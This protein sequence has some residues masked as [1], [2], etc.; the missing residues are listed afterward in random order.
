MN[1]NLSALLI[2]DYRPLSSVGP[3]IDSMINVGGI[4][5]TP[6]KQLPTDIQQFLDEAEHGAIYFSLGSQ[7]E[8]K[9]MPAEKL[10]I[11]LQVFSQ[12]KQRVLWKFE[13]DT[14]TNLPS[15]VMVK[16][17]LPQN[18]ILAHPNV[19]VFIAHGGLF[20]TQEA[21]YH[22]VPI[23]GMPFYCDQVSLTKM[24]SNNKY[25]N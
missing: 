4:H 2:N 6:P 13:N 12:L 16:K 10:R 8:S 3:T 5:I 24:K 1:K 14:I 19:R 22:A 18:D 7:V 15:N 25:T 9:D 17:W 21:V 23:L 11:F 20:G